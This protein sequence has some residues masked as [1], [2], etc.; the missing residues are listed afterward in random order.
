LQAMKTPS[1]FQSVRKL[2][3]ILEVK[4]I[5]VSVLR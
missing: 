5:Q 4:G 2:N 3:A 1:R